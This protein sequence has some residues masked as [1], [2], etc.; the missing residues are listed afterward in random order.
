[1]IAGSPL[2]AHGTE[3][4]LAAL[5]RLLGMGYDVESVEHTARKINL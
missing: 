3:L 4:T 5:L 1:M 2:E